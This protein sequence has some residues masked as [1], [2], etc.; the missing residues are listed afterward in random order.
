MRISPVPTTRPGRAPCSARPVTAATAKAV[1]D[2][3]RP[4]RPASIGV[5]CSTDWSR[6]EV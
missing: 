4:I 2:S 5:I 3:G 6:L 1:T